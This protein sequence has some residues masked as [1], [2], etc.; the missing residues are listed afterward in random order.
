MTQTSAARKPSEIY[1]NSEDVEYTTDS[2]KAKYTYHTTRVSKTESNK[3]TA[4]PETTNLE[5][6]T[7]THI[8][9]VG[10]MIVGWGGNNGSTVTASLIAH[11]QNISWNTK[12]CIQ[13]PNFLGSLTQCST[14]KLGV[15]EEGNDIFVPLNSMLPMV[16]PA[17]LVVGGW[18]IMIFYF[19][20]SYYNF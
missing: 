6:K 4:T 13:K 1:V 17:E 5:F 16:N 7:T 19:I 15:D 18:G 11:Q 14:V 3:F 12:E 10:M 8:G 9:R 2:I 20:S